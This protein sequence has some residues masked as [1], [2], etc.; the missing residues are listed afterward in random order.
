MRLGVVSG[1]SKGGLGQEMELFPFRLCCHQPTL[2]FIPAV[3]GFAVAIT[4]TVPCTHFCLPPSLPSL[5]PY[6]RSVIH[7]I[8][9][10]TQFDPAEMDRM[11][12]TTGGTSV[13]CSDSDRLA[14]K[15]T[16]ALQEALSGRLEGPHLS[17]KW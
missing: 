7:T 4:H 10:G 14:G 15:L 13:A 3:V 9:L 5:A 11:A 16:R 1:A 12:A 17:W 6:T 8:G 2:P